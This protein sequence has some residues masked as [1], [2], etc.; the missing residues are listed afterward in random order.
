MEENIPSGPDDT[1][2]FVWAV[3]VIAIQVVIAIRVIVPCCC[4]C[5]RVVVE[6]VDIK[7]I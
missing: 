3:S 1:T 6:V 2:G 7:E 4:C 5:C